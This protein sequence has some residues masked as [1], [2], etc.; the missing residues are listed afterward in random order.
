[1]RFEQSGRH[2]DNGCAWCDSR[3]GVLGGVAFAPRMELVGSG[4]M[5]RRHLLQKKYISE[6][7]A[8]FSLFHHQLR[9][10]AHPG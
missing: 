9:V 8:Q 6:K 3:L 7:R 10:F 2:C 4:T 5:I 1:M